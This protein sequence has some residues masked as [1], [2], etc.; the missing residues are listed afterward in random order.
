MTTVTSQTINDG[1]R[2]VV[3]KFNI[4]GTA[5]ELTDAL[6]VD[7]ST[8]SETPDN[9]KIMGIQSALEGFGAE[10]IWDATANVS[11]LD[12]PSGQDFDQCYRKFGGLVNNSGAGKT[13]DILISTSGAAVGLTGHIVLEM[14]KRA[15]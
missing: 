2:N 9:V 6:L 4:V 15:A 14:W 11:I 5:V 3:M 1:P 10:L 13:G 12:I 7:V 8:L